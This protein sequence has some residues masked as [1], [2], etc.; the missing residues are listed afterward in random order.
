MFYF[1]QNVSFSV[2]Q[3]YTSLAIKKKVETYG[4][5]NSFFILI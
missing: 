2:Y 5:E 1:S 3:H 4:S